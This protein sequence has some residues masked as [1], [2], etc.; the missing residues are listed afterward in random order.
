MTINAA[1]QNDLKRQNLGTPLVWAESPRH[2]QVS[3]SILMQHHF[4]SDDRT[5]A[6]RL[7]F[8]TL[9]PKLVNG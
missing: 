1:A 3:K 8:A 4:C 6:F 2:H 9:L 7:V 5:Q